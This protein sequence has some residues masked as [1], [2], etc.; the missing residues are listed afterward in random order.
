MTKEQEKFDRDESGYSENTSAMQLEIDAGEW[1]R[2]PEFLS[3]RRR[4]RQGK[5]IATYQ[6]ISNR[7][8]QL[9]ALYY[10][11]V[12]ENPQRSLKL[13]KEIKRLR[14]L[15]KFLLDC[16]VWEQK[17]ELEEHDIPE[18]LREVF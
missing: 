10:E 7:L 11:L 18:E 9:V 3:Y 2:L 12:K 8:N 5:I 6:A 15:Q 4:S 14:F 17:G 1:T 16:L 13:L